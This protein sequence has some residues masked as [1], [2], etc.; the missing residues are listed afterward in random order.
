MNNA[1][2][3]YTTTEKNIWQWYMLWRNSNT[4]C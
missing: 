1:T 2:N 3:N 4:I